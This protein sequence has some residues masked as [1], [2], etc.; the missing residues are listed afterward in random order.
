MEK[1]QDI[2]DKDGYKRIYWYEEFNVDKV[3]SSNDP[4]IAELKKSSKKIILDA[5]CGI[6]SYPVIGAALGHKTIGIDISVESIKIAKSVANKFGI[7]GLIVGDVRKLPFKSNTFDIV[8]SGGV[9][10][11]FIETEEA[12]IE[13]YRV[14]KNNSNL[15]I[16]V[17]HKMSFYVLN[18]LF[19]QATGLWPCGYEASFTKKKFELMLKKTGFKIE[20]FRRMEALPGRRFPI[21]GK[22]IR[23]LDK[24]IFPFRAGG[25]HIYF[26]CKK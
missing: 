12:L 7:S 17:P 14:L 11:H 3:I 6:G 13:A 23:I 24:M 25:A 19:Q 5:G 18:K 10:E 8:T 1:L 2:W 16:N 15:L 4:F 22:I 9:V 26:K 20:D 21:V